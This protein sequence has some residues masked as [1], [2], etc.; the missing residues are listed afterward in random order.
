MGLLNLFARENNNSKSPLQ[1][2]QA[3]EK[4][5]KQLGIPYIDHL[6]YI[7]SEEEAKIRTAQ[8]ITKRVLILAYLLYI[9]EVPQ[10]KDN[11][12]N[13]FKEYDIWDHVSPDE[14]RLLEL[15]N[16]DE[17]DKTNV[18]WRA[19]SLWVLLWSIRL[20]DKLT[21]KDDFVIAQ[22]IIEKLP[23][24][25]SDPSEFI[26]QVRIRATADILDFSDLIYRTHWAV[27][28]AYLEGK[29]APAALSSSTVM[30]RHYA[31]NWIT[32]QADEWDEVTTDT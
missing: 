22:A 6:P 9:L 7:E 30:E 29:P 15:D 24:F 2:K 16:W 25:L 32:F 1:R 23:E 3:S 18:S 12:T 27:R 26:R 11:I 8:D 10:Q 4:I 13:Y 20:V 14:R 17:Q 28:N 21:L 31:V 5:L 19:E